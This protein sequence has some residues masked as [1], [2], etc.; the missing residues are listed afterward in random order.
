VNGEECVRVMLLSLNQAT[1]VWTSLDLNQLQ[2]F[3]SKGFKD[4]ICVF[5][6][7]LEIKYLV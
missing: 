4:A 3:R 7:F 5:D 6:R 2:L 1:E